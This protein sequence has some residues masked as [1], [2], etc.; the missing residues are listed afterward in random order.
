[1]SVDP[2]TW[3][4]LITAAKN[5]QQNAHAPYSNFR[6]GAALLATD[7]TIFAGCNVENASF[8]ATVCAERTAIG[9]AVSN[10]H[11]SFEALVVI[12]P[13]DHTIA[14]CG[15]CRQVLSEFC[16]DLPIL[17]LDGSDNREEVTLDA[18]LPHRFKGDD[19]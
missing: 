17:L 8:S 13:A 3:D 11:Q 2:K 9:A 15:I 19:I 16:A 10:G 6:V 18:L 12:T 4:T 5:A 1:M 14:P 7:G